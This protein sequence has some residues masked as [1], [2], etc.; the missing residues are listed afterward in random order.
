MRNYYIP[1]YDD[2]IAAKKSGLTDKEILKLCRKE[3]G[4]EWFAA[5]RQQLINNGVM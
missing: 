2:V 1:T 4:G 3:P 5:N